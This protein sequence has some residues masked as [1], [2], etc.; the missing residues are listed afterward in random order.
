MPNG[1]KVEL[2]AGGKPND[3]WLER[4]NGDRAANEPVEGVGEKNRGGG[5]DM[6][7]LEVGDRSPGGRIGSLS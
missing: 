1:A 5:D 4:G 7:V 2:I 3:P 6:K